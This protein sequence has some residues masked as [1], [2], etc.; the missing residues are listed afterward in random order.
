MWLS[1]LGVGGGASTS[2][3]AAAKQM[4]NSVFAIW[5]SENLLQ[6]PFG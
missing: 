1:L 4:L 5:K 2:L 3:T 6:I